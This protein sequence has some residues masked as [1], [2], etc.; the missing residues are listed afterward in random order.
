MSKVLKYAMATA[1]LFFGLSLQ[2]AAAQS[3]MRESTCTHTSD[4]NTL[5]YDCA[6]NVKYY[7]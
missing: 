2:P 7:H 1:A 4:S 5:I 3:L 6:F